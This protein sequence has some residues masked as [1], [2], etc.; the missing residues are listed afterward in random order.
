MSIADFERGMEGWKTRT[1]SAIFLTSH[2]GWVPLVGRHKWLW[3]NCR[4]ENVLL[5]R[6]DLAKSPYVS[7]QNRLSITRVCSGFYTGEVQFGPL[8][9]PCIGTVLPQALP[10]DW[11]DAVFLLP[12]PIA[13]ARGGFWRVLLQRTYLFLSKTGLTPIEWFQIEPHKAIS[14]GLELDM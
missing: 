10:F 2:L 3:E 8:V 4:Y 13:T 5:L 9:N 12:R 11:D 7:D 6:V 14:V 1:G